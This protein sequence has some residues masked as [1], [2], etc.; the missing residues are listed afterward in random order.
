MNRYFFRA[1]YLFTFTAMNFI[2]YSQSATDFLS[3]NYSAISKSEFKD[4]IGE[5]QLS[6]FDFNFVTPTIQLNS[7]TKINNI[8]YYRF[9]EYQYSSFP[10]LL[11]IV[12]QELHE[13]KYT[14]LTRHKFNAKWE[15]LLV[16]RISI[17]SDF[18]D[19]LNSND[20]F[21]AVSTIV[22]KT[23]QKNERLKWGLGLNYNNDLG[24]NSIIPILA[25]S[26]VSDKMKFISYFPNNANLTFLPSKKIEYGFGF[27]ADPTL[28][29]I[30]TTDSIDY[31]RTLNVAVNPTFS[32]NLTSNFWL[33]T[34][35]GWV[36]RRN[37]D[38][39]NSNFEPPS[40]DFEN[41]LKSSVFLQIGLS[42]RT[43]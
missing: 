17:R 11:E 2:S 33:N 43:K 38:F 23:S 42:L 40:E 14:L 4:K 21:P 26:Y 30:N 19:N 24:K 25:F 37:F 1:F 20:L 22:M 7:K 15:L 35:A 5:A 9:S 39:Y 6:H 10:N 3:I 36:L 16:P 28:F 41:Q 29:H 18:K 8:I 27:T 34:K 13:V 12:P 32:Y 31:L